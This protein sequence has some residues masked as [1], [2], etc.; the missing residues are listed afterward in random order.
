MALA[1][2][3]EL[4]ATEPFPVDPAGAPA[5]DG[6]PE[7]APAA[8]APKPATSGVINEFGV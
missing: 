8:V 1:G 4:E 3:P 6:F 7:A 5:A 2:A